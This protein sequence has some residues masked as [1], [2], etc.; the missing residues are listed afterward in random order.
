M[1][2]NLAK[3]RLLAGRAHLM[4]G[5]PREAIEA[6]AE[7]VA[8]ADE[9]AHGSLR[10]LGRLW[11]G[12]ALRAM[13]RD[14]ADIYREA[15]DHVASLARGLDDDR[16]RATF[17]SSERVS[18]LRD[19]LAAAEGERPAERPAGLTAREVD[20]LRLLAQH[21]TDKE[22]AEA[23]FLSPRTV[24]THVANILIKLN[25]ANRREAAT[26]AAGLGLD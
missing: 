14:A 2:K 18:E 10:W 8:L 20:V 4:Q 9:I 5:R 11:L 26:A 21:Q 24:S 23:L 1:K 6:L 19:S 15:M 7:S 17:L 16:L 3:S 12:H 22:I 25:V 13:R